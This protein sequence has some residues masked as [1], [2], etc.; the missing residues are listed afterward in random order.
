MKREIRVFLA[1]A[2]LCLLGG[3]SAK[4]DIRISEVMASN[5][6]FED[7]HAWDWVELYNDGKS[8]VDLSGW[9][10]SDSKSNPLKW[11]FPQGAK[12]KGGKY[13]TVFC[14]GEAGLDPGKGSVFYAPFAISAS[15]ESL[16]LS[17]AAG[18]EVQRLT[19]PPQ[20]GCVSYGLPWKGSEYGYLESPTRG[21]RNSGIAYATRTETPVLLTAG[22]FYVG[23]VTVLAE[24]PEGA[25]LRYTLDGETPTAKSKTFPAKGLNL[26]KTSPL[27]VRAFREDAVPS[28]TVSATCGERA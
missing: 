28:E 27:R 3:V 21:S 22:G 19:L 26:K 1:A 11:T 4:A 17:D 7:G 2:L 9:H 13:L 10:L 14:A 23:S 5:G 12:L 16:I 8:A 15:G 25:T 20:Y 24:A 6:Y 18:N